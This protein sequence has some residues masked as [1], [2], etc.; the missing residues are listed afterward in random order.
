VPPLSVPLP[1]S[2]GPG[3]CPDTNNGSAGY[4]I[5]S[6]LGGT[7]NLTGFRVPLIVVSPYAKPNFVSHVPRDYTAI[8]AYIES[9]FGVPPLTARDAYWQASSR[10]MNEFFDFSTPALLTGPGG[11]P[12]AQILTSQTTT[13]ICDDTKEAGPTM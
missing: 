11:V 4:C 3:Q 9:T 2:Y 8:L 10:D 7:F 5:T 1:D 6:G 13:G 12:W